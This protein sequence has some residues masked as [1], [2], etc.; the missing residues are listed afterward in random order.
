LSGLSDYNISINS[1]MTVSCNC[2]DYFGEA[3]IGDMSK[4]SFDEIW[5]GPTARHLRNE[6]AEGRLPL[7]QCAVCNELVTTPDIQLAARHAAGPSF[8]KRGIMIENTALC[9]VDCIGCR[10]SV[11]GVRRKSMSM[12]DLARALDVARS[13]E[14]RRIAFLNLGE[15]FLP[16]NVLDQMKL[17]R[18]VLPEV[19]ILCSTGGLCMESDDRL[20][21]ALMTD[22]I[23]FSLDGVDQETVS[24]YQRRQDFNKVYQSMARLVE[25]RDRR[26]SK[27]PLIY[28]KYVLFKWNQ[29]PAQIQA[30][31]RLARQANVDAI[32]FW[33]TD[34]PFWAVPEGFQN[35]ENFPG[36]PILASLPCI[37]ALTLR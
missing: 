21:A 35:D 18:R 33:N 22:I 27:K 2:Q 5:L 28:W 34:W 30:A 7:G 17:V 25:I 14:V 24:V 11:L 13:H 20:E 1:D 15:P 26:G 8:P 6:L 12:E 10:K 19:E 32:H 16:G 9:N 31:V 29:S 37:R 23:A 4:Q 3:L 36:V